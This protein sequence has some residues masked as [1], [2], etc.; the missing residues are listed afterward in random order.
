MDRVTKTI[1]AGTGLLISAAIAQQVRRPPAERTWQGRIVG[2]PY[3][4]RPPTPSLLRASFWDPENP[5]L[6]TP[7]VFG[8]GWGGINIY[9]LLHPHA[10]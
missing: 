5:S 9:R 8:V 3:D 1:L 10:A 4:F 6:L 7:K 2:I